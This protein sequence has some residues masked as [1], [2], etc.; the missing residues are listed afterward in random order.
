MWRILPTGETGS[1]KFP[2]APVPGA[3]EREKGRS[4]SSG[5]FKARQTLQGW[6]NTELHQPSLLAHKSN[7]KMMAALIPGMNEKTKGCE[8]STV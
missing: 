8:V 3:W 7:S 6:V 4:V 2:R 1:S 5:S